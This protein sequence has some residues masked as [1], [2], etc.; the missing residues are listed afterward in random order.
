MPGV[1]SRFSVIVAAAGFAEVERMTKNA[2]T[3]LKTLPTQMPNFMNVTAVGLLAG[4]SFGVQ[5][6]L[7]PALNHQDAASYITTMQGIIP[8]FTHAAIPL[9]MI[10]LVTFLVRLLWLRSPCAGMQY[11]TLASFG[12]FLAGAWITI[13]G[14]W[15]LNNQ[16]IHWAAQNPP[17]EW[18]HLRERWSQLNFW[19]FAVA[20]PG[21]IA[22]LIPFVF[23][24]NRKA[25]LSANRE[26]EEKQGNPMG[27]AIDFTVSCQR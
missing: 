19:R 20:Q 14:H 7:V 4:L 17:A 24:R 3:Q 6:G 15:P 18:E 26:Q 12:F 9:M 22:L 16:L 1:A 27:N 10:G 2:T 25:G 23:A 13:C 8:T 5:F 21:F 11:W